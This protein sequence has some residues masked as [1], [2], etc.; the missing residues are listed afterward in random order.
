MNEDMLE[1]I[2]YLCQGSRYRCCYHLAVLWLS[3]LSVVLQKYILIIFLLKAYLLIIIINCVIGLYNVFSNHC[4]YIWL[5][6]YLNNGIRTSQSTVFPHSHLKMD[7][8]IFSLILIEPNL[9]P[10]LHK[11]TKRDWSAL[12]YVGLHEWTGWLGRRN[13]CYR[14]T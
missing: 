13:G 3:D 7:V 8:S 11:P 5:L 10:G 4:I 14:S 6:E 12:K 9:R 2:Y 1:I